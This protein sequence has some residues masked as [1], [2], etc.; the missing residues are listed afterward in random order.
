MKKRYFA[1]LILLL[2]ICCKSGERLTSPDHYII[3]KSIT[4]RV[5]SGSPAEFRIEIIPTDGFEMEVEAPVKLRFDKE[6]YTDV[7]FE[8][9]LYTKE[10]LLNRNIKKPVFTGRLTPKKSGSFQVKGDLSFVV[11]TSSI[12]EPKKAEIIF[13]FIAE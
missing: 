12:C 11:C 2:F 13:D 8:K 7:E 1:L 3:K 4:E 10:D 9:E 6:G 5:K